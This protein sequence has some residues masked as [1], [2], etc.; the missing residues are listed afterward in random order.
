[1]H[2]DSLRCP[3]DSVFTLSSSCQLS[4]FVESQLV[5]AAQ[6]GRADDV[7]ELVDEGA[8]IDFVDEVRHGLVGDLSR[9]CALACSRE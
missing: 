9:L 1:M 5:D 6:S 7:R 3:R 4:C 8:L 2:L